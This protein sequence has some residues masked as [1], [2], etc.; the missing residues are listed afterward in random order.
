MIVTT[1]HGD[2]DTSVHFDLS[3]E[4]GNDQRFVRAWYV[5]DPVIDPV[6][7]EGFV[8]SVEAGSPVNFRN[9][10]F[11]PHGHGTHTETFGH[12]SKEIFSVNK[13]CFPLFMK[14]KLITVEPIEVIHGSEYD[15]VIVSESLDDLWTSTDAFEALILRTEWKGNRLNMDYSHQNPPFLDVD[16]A[17]RLR[18]MGI[19][20]LLIDLPSVDKENDEG[21]LAFHHA[22]WDFPEHPD[23]ERTITEFIH[24]DRSIPDGT[25]LLNL[26]VAPFENDAAP[27][28]PIIYPIQ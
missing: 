16:I 1:P 26:Q 17:H 10:F 19:Q 21:V 20:H 25:Y 6:V 13:V 9:I 11:N 2:I 28:R 5:N 15:H 22:F 8:G 24:V 12:I 18:Q 3:V 23:T 14:A 4:I 7:G 27:S